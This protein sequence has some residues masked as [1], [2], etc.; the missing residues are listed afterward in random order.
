[1]NVTRSATPLAAAYLIMAAHALP[2]AAAATPPAHS[3]A[4]TRPPGTPIPC[5][6]KYEAFLGTW[7]GEFSAYV[8]ER[9]GRDRAV[10]RPYHEQVTYS[11]RDCFTTGPG[12][13]SFIVGH[14]VDDYPPS[15]GLPAKQTSELL[16]T[17]TRGD[18]TRFLRTVGKEG[19][20]DFSLT[21]ENQ[22]AGLR[23]WTL[24]IPAAG[25]SPAMT[26]TVIDSRDLVAADSARRD[27]VVTLSVG[28]GKHPFWR[29]VIVRG[30]HTRSSATD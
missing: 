17:G 25:Q 19:V 28:P 23:V 9:S 24:R 30:S 2:A 20:N 7:S 16:V 18:G 8:R 1:M 5:S 12:G 27:V 11:A 15:A 6:G 4:A 10:F 3:A 26:Y 21:Y 13:E 22:A 14:R 29:G